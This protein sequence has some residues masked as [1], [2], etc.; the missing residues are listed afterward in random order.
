MVCKRLIII[1]IVALGAICNSQEAMAGDLRINI[2][3]RSQL[4][5][6]QRL[7]REGVEAVRKHQ[8]DRA[9]DLFYKAYL[10]DPDDPF[11]LNNLAYIAELDGQLERAQTFY[12]LASK[13]ATEAV[14]DRAS[15]PRLEGRSFQNAINGIQDARMRIDRANTEAVRLLSEQRLSEADFLLQRTLQLDPKNPF[16]LNNMGVTKETEGDFAE[17]LKFYTAAS[18]AHSEEPVIVTLNTASRGQSISKVASESARK[19]RQR[20]DTLENPDVR[21]ALLNLRGVSAVNRNDWQEAAQDFLQAY[22]LDPNSAFS[23]NNVGFL[24]EMYGDPETAQIFYE[25]AQTAANSNLRVGLATRQSAEGLKLFAVAT[26]SDQ[27]VDTEISQ[28]QAAKR[29]ESNPIQLKR[30]DGKPVTDTTPQQP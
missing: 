17:A 23:L 22:K 9:R 16:T 10:F 21:A 5:P 25:K 15:T 4:T 13:Q 3:K 2:P 7:N 24:S 19:V 28:E 8:F 27:N 29:R 12:D 14:I 30:R 6:V 26:D 20:M 11:T 18:N 1:S